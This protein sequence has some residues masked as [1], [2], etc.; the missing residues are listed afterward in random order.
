M[1]NNLP[2]CPSGFFSC[3]LLTLVPTILLPVSAAAGTYNRCEQDSSVALDCLPGS[4][5]VTLPDSFKVNIDPSATV[6][7]A[8]FNWKVKNCKVRTGFLRGKL[9]LV[10]DNS[11]SAATT[12]PDATRSGVLNSFMQNFV[13]RSFGSGVAPGQAGYPQLA[14]VN[15][16]GRSG[17]ISTT[18]RTDDYNPAFTPSF[19]ANTQPAFPAAAAFTRWNENSG[20]GKLNICEFLGLRETTDYSSV[21]D[22]QQFA[23]FAAA[24]P[25][26]ETDFTYFFKA[27]GSIFPGTDTSTVGKHVLLITDGLPNVPKNVPESTCKSTP[28]LRNETIVTGNLLGVQR[29]Y[30]VDR[31]AVQEVAR[32]HEEALKSDYSRINFHHVLYTSARRAYFDYDAN[33]ELKLSPAEF[34]IENSARTGNGKVKFSYAK[35]ESTLDSELKKVLESMDAN[36]LQYVDVRVQ[37]AGG[38]SALN[39][40]A[41][42]PGAPQQEFSIKFIG[43]KTGTN[44]VTVTP[45][46]QDGSQSSKTFTVVAEA[47]AADGKPCSLADDNK[48]VDGDP[49]GSKTPKGDGFYNKPNSRG[50]LRDYRNADPA[51]NLA[52]REFASVSD[53]QDSARLTK[54]RLQGGTGNCGVV[55]AAQGERSS[56]ASL[57]NVLLLL[58]APLFVLGLRKRRS[59]GSL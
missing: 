26:G 15:Y 37:P 56:A 34:L 35:E 4:G 29:N 42:S 44:T 5:T 12:D 2:I 13:S 38:G 6:T 54:L 16:N 40:R 39:Y 47:N 11:A 48:T 57:W 24:E 7:E 46:Y 51:N 33:G 14:L 19:C 25:R 20:S 32:A 45:V 22:L 53:T 21:S 17:T 30:C 58:V 31:Q 50:D 43:L 3:A 10:L 27:A 28:R 49:I 59:G 8:V 23:T 18:N 9:A 41:V 55:A 36:A 52:D 1:R